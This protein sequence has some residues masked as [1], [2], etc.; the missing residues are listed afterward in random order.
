[1]NASSHIAMKKYMATMGM[2]EVPPGP[3]GPIGPT[4]LPGLIEFTGST[5][6]TGYTGDRGPTGYTGMPGKMGYTGPGYTGPTG[7]IGPMGPQGFMGPIGSR[8]PTGPTSFTGPTGPHTLDTSHAGYFFSN[9]TQN[10]TIPP[11][12]PTVLTLDTSPVCRGIKLVESTRIM[13]TKTALYETYY[14]V[15]VHRTAGSAG[16]YCY[17]WLRKNGRDIPSTNGRIEAKPNGDTMP[18]VPYILPLH[19][20]DYLEFVAQAEEINVQA[21][22]LVPS[23]GPYIPSVI[24]GI[25]EVG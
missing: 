12:T 1:M 20:G 18:I 4:G 5:G 24:V 22:S 6:D 19:A 14:S 2:I 16:T 13:V 21:L 23:I 25:K 11:A 17:I 8:G 7:P 3:T 9:T 10:I 15:K